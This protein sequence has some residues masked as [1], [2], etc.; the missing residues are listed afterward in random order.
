MTDI[1]KTNHWYDSFHFLVNTA[2]RRAYKRIEVVGLEN[3]PTDGAVILAGNHCNTLMD[4]LVVLRARGMKPTVFG[5]RADLYNNPTVGKIVRFLKI[6]PMV[7]E[8]DG[9]RNVVKNFDTM[10]QIADVIGDG[11]PFCFYPEGTHRPKHS[12]LPIRKGLTRIA[13]A[14]DEK[15]PA[16]MPIY[17]VPVGIEYGDYFRFH[18]TNLV[19]FGKPVEIRSMLREAEDKNMHFFMSMSELYTKKISELITYIPDDENYDGV[20]S[21]TKIL[22]SGSSAVS[23][24]FA[25][26]PS[27]SLALNRKTVAAIESKMQSQ[28]EKM[29]RLVAEAAEFEE[30]R[31]ASGISIYSFFEKNA[32]LNVALRAVWAVISLIAAVV[33]GVFCLPTLIAAK[34]LCTKVFK[35]RCFHNTG[36]LVTNFVLCPILTTIWFVAGLVA[37]NWIAALVFGLVS[38]KAYALL[39]DCMGSMRKTVSDFKLLAN[40]GLRNQWKSLRSRFD[41]I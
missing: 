24:A 5:A 23:Q 28:P 21:L 33:F 34:V 18:S 26:S 19:T 11:V 30:K 15:L 16:D 7:R 35:D 20:W 38:L 17:M 6:L 25:A 2:V 4:A 10:D 12:L 31:K 29:A 41:A 39:W 9:L 22:R 32:A 40:A 27:E 3:I 36:R 1:H 8:R 13:M 37:Y 14:A